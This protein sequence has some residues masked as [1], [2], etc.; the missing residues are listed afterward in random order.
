MFDKLLHPD[1]VAV[2]GA[3]ADR[4]KIGSA[5]LENMRLQGFSGRILPVNPSCKEISGLPCYPSI[6]DIEGDI[7]I[8]VIALPAKAALKALE[9]CVNKAVNFVI[10]IAGGFSELG[11]EG[12]LLEKRIGEIIHG[13]GTR[14]IG[15]NTVG[16]IFP[17]SRVNTAL[18]PA[19]RISFPSAG[20]IAF[21]SQ[22]G[23]LGLLV[24]DSISEHGTG[25]S[26]FVNIGNR[27]DITEE[28]LIEMFMEDSSTKSIVMY[29]ESISD[30]EKFFTSIRRANRR[31]PLV[32]LKTGRTGAASRAASFHTG[33]MASDDRVLDGIL[34]QAGVTRAYNEVELLDFGKALAYSI[35]PRGNRVAVLTTAGGVGVVTTDLLASPDNG[36]PLSMAEFSERETA[37]MRKHVLPIASVANPIDLTADG[38]VEAFSSI[39]EILVESSNVDAI[40]AYALPQTP[41]IDLSIVEPLKR[42]AAGKTTVVGVIGHRMAKGLLSGLERAGVPAYPSTGR[43]VSSLRALCSYGEYL[44]R[45]G[46]EQ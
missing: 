11:E 30:G 34:K 38:S 35:L 39:M 16:V 15:P 2:I 21:I 31:K 23:A 18:T 8:A 40:M 10:I 37:E 22:S 7:D 6:E 20:D 29:L 14:V 45:H 27:A 41:K 5:V 4:S 46:H 32:V 43:A 19:E 13:T 36:P 17:Q 3:S 24:M 26:G 33:A 12:K 9:Q 1:S 25:I 44:R 28:D 42:A